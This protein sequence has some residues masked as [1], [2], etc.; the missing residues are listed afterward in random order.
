MYF[1]AENRRNEPDGP[2][3]PSII[4]IYSRSACSEVFIVE[5]GFSIAETGDAQLR[6]LINGNITA[7]VNVSIGR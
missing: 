1:D 5:M 2:L 6:L 7:T 3:F 4:C